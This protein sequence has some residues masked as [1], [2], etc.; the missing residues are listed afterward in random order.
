LRPAAERP[1]IS[2][3][4]PSR[5]R[6]L[7]GLFSTI[8]TAGGVQFRA[9]ADDGFHVAATGES[10]RQNAGACLACGAVENGL[11]RLSPLEKFFLR[12]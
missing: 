11:N 6:R 1:G 5:V 4:K 7:E 3:L 8:K 10:F 2:P 12:Q 9:I